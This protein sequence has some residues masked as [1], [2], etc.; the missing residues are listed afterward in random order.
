MLPP[1]SPFGI[2]DLIEI[3]P[4]TL[5][6]CGRERQ[7]APIVHEGRRVTESSGRC[8]LASPRPRVELSEEVASSHPPTSVSDPPIH[9][10]LI[11]SHGMRPESSLG[12][13]PRRELML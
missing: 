2:I 5:I 10:K 7:R 1:C 6:E 9:E 11:D 3:G 13:F 12:H 8:A 4:G